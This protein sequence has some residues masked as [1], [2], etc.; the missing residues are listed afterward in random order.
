MM[1][2]VDAAAGVAEAY[3]ARAGDASGPLPGVLLFMDAI[4]LRPQLQAMADRIASWGY[5]V[6][7]PNVFYRHGR[8]ADLAPRRPLLEEWD[9][10]DFFAEAMPRVRGLTPALS[11]PDTVA[12]IAALTRITGASARLGVVG[13][14]MGARL[15]TRAACDHPDRVAACAGF[16]GGGLASDAADS[17]HLGLPHA[18]AEFLYGHADGDAS[19]GRADVARLD[20]ALGAAGLRATTAVY[21]GAR[22]GYTMADTAVYDAAASER[23]FEELRGLLARTIAD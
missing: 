11:A 8:A 5:V 13:Y 7:V 10:A 14:C 9:R 15:A 21:P 16:H 4:G 6:L 1:I 19:M 22:H 17:P 23:H 2:E 20:R 12:W 3:V 18:R